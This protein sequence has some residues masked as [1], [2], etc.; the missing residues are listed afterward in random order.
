MIIRVV[1]IEQNKYNILDILAAQNASFSRIVKTDN[2]WHLL[3]ADND[4]ITE[5]FRYLHSNVY[6]LTHMK[7]IIRSENNVC[8]VEQLIRFQRHMHVLYQIIHS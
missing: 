4:W 6:I 3:E 7:S 1:Y 8:V 5:T 2:F